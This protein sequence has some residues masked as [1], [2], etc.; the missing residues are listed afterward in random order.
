MEGV[1]VICEVLNG[2]HKRRNLEFYSR[3]TLKDFD[4]IKWPFL[5]HVMEMKGFPK[6]WI[7]MVMKVV[8][9]GKVGVRVNGETGPYFSTYQAFR[10][11][12]P[13]SPLLFDST[14]DVL[15]MLVEWAKNQGLI[16]G[17][18]DDLVDGG[19]STQ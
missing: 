12:D 13:L 19:V 18:S 1:C 15:V 14:V 3:L 11:C 5:V 17:L 2:T 8:T 7:D 10:Q 9:S 6:E 4:K 16:S